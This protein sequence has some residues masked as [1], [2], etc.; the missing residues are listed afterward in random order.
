MLFENTYAFRKR[1]I[2]ISLFYVVY[3]VLSIAALVQIGLENY[4]FGLIVPIVTASLHFAFALVAMTMNDRTAMQ[5]NVAKLVVVFD[6][7]QSFA[8]AIASSSLAR[9]DLSGEVGW[10]VTANVIQLCAQLVC[11]LKTY[12]LLNSARFD[13]DD[14]T[15]L[16]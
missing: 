12:D 13:Q 8:L 5:T 2:A 9:D 3:F 11:A 4:R 10:A 7:A 16:G 6:W 15:S 14:G 1:V